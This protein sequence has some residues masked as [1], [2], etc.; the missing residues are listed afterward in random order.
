M[1]NTITAVFKD[2][3]VCTK[4]KKR[5][6]KYGILPPKPTPEIIPWHTLCIDLIGPYKFGKEKYPK[7]FAVL[8]CLTMIDPA[9]GFFD[10]IEIGEKQADWIANHLETTWLS[11]YP[12]PTEIVMDKGKE[13]ALEVQECTMPFYPLGYGT[14]GCLSGPIPGI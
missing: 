4:Q 3:P 8:H 13:F 12:W 10:I 11:R 9:T 7:T 2:C 5:E 14:K 1:R 6:N